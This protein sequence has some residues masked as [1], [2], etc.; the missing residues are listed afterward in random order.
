MRTALAIVLFLTG[1]VLAQNTIGY[2]R[3]AKRYDRSQLG[4]I[5]TM[6]TSLFTN[7]VMWQTFSA[8]D[9]TNYYDAASLNNAVGIAS[10][11]W[12]NV[13][14]GAIRFNGSSQFA[15]S[16]VADITFPLT[17]AVWVKSLEDKGQT[18]MSVARSDASTTYYGSLEQRSGV[19]GIVL[20]NGTFLNATG[21]TVIGTAAWR[22]IAGVFTATNGT[23]YVNGTQEAVVASTAPTGTG[24]VVLGALRL[25]GADY[26]NSILG[27]AR[28]FNRVLTSN[29]VVN[30][31]NATKGDYGQ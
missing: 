19:A 8:N 1:S 3:T 22:H 29:E 5:S 26:S 24:L 2:S 14:G 20:R 31:Y 6:P 27:D 30:L 9:G 21:T 17:I 23:L 15:T 18:F 12:T 13:V 25:P 11:T 4:K 7:C 10:P 16:H 28:Y